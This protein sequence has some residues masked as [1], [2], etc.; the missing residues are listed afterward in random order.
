MRT[1]ALA[2]PLAEGDTLTVEKRSRYLHPIGCDIVTLTAGAGGIAQ[3]E[4]EETA[5][6]E[7]Y[8]A[9]FA[10]GKTLPFWV[11]EG[12]SVQEIDLTG[13]IYPRNAIQNYEGRIEEAAA[14]A[15][16]MIDMSV[17]GYPNVNQEDQRLGCRYAAYESGEED[18]RVCEIDTAI[19]NP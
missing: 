18:M 12:E 10:G 14:N 2:T 6:D 1:V 7:C 17:C 8:A 4:L 5:Q 3:A 11:Y 19:G 15:V 16:R 9:V 13:P